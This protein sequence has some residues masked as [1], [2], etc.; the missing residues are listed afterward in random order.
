MASATKQEEFL[1]KETRPQI[2]A[3][4]KLPG[5]E[6]MSSCHLVEKMNYIFVHVVK[7]VNLPTK[8]A[9][10][11][12]CN[13][14]VEVK[15]GDYKV[16]TRHVEKEVN[17]KWDQVFTF[18]KDQVQAPI[19][20][21]VIKDKIALG[22]NDI[23]GKSLAFDLN[24][25]P[26]CDRQNPL[27]PQWYSLDGTVGE[28]A[29]EGELLLA[30]WMGNQADRFF[31][32]AW[33]S[34]AATM[35]GEYILPKLWYV[36][37]NVIEAQ[38]LVPSDSGRFSK[39]RVLA[40]LGNQTCRTRTSDS[41]SI[42]PLW[43]EDLLFVVAEPFAEQ[44]VLTVED[45]G[46]LG[47]YETLARCTIPVQAVER[48]FDHKP[49][50]SRWYSLSVDAIADEY[51]R[52][53]RY[54]GRIH[55]RIC[56][57][58]GYHVLSE[59]TKLCT[60][61]KPTGKQLWTPAI[62]VLELG[63][64]SA[65]GLV[66]MKTKDD[67]GRTDS[68]CVAK[69]GVKWFRTRTITDNSNP[70]WNEQHRW[71]VFDPYTMITIA[72]FDDYHIHSYGGE[73]DSKMGK[74]KIRVSSLES[75][76][77]NRYR[78]PLLVLHSSGVK[79]MGE[80]ELV[81]RF[82]CTSWINMMQLYSRPVL[83][84]MHY[85]YP[86]KV[87]HLDY[88]RDSAVDIISNRL[89]KAEPPLRKE[90]VDYLL[91]VDSTTWSSRKSKANFLKVKNFLRWFDQ[92][93]KWERPSLTIFIHIL[94]TTL[95]FYP[96]VLPSTVFFSLFLISIWN[97]RYRR[98]WHQPH[99]DSHSSLGDIDDLNDL[100]EE[101]DT[102]PT[103]QPTY[104]VKVRYDHLRSKASRFQAELEDWASVCER[105]QSLLTWTDPRG[106]ALFLPL[107]ICTSLLLYYIEFRVI[108][109]VLGFYL[110]RHPWLRIIKF[111]LAPVNFFSRLPSKADYML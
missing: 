97:Y 95:L 41:E 86:I 21:V 63:V 35:S 36:R 10:T 39:V 57:E 91:D 107:C 22:D 74:V 109:A 103:S 67:R 84:K 40:V 93:Y 14:Y 27:A 92:I 83:P 53:R 108:A 75:G 1:L 54:Y 68:Y 49:V 30:I 44:L 34:D 94:L 96:K 59:A 29:T 89:G 81:V 55:L 65:H 18:P 111:P 3:R 8:D 51:G 23:I 106:T 4:R 15:L 32:Q 11:G 5:H 105:L 90:V 64:I 80:I 31:Q 46:G 58:G 20:E 25:I 69:Y 13:P 110:L 71:E 12:S 37:V 77:I 50:A 7:A 43:N 60:D 47:R 61:F 28:D 70:K 2:G 85:I 56:L 26:I 100:D 52:Q 82:T 42:N 72:V 79:K 33:H 88:L 17:P 38:D 24:Q 87:Q 45:V 99:I 98:V 66:P 48:R 78:Y 101:F 19:A 6:E 104:T 102:F 16:T 62:G 76:Q 9:N 73:N